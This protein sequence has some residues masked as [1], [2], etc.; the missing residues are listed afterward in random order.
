MQGS[1]EPDVL[2]NLCLALGITSWS[3][4]VLAKAPLIEFAVV[5][6]DP[7]VDSWSQKMLPAI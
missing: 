6:E 5:G 3:T 2:H 1:E 7:T 4:Y